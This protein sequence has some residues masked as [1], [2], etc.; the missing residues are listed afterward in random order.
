MQVVVLESR[1]EQL[2][3]AL[4]A[5]SGHRTLWLS[6]ELDIIHAEPEYELEDEG[7]VYVATLMRPDRETLTA[8]LLRVVQVEGSLTVSRPTLPRRVGWE[9][10]AEPELVGEL[11]P[12]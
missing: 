10:T 2:T 6:P 4:A 5:F 12:A 9:L 7:Y 1:V 11:V 3:E 8:A